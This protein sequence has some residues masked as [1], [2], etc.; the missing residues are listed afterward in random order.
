MVSASTSASVLLDRESFKITRH[1]LCWLLIAVVA[2]IVPHV[3]RMPLWLIAI[4]TLCLAG[5]YLIFQG[6]MSYPG[7]KLKML[8]VCSM[9]LLVAM[10]YGRNVFSTDATVALLLVGIALKLLEMHQKR[11]VLVVLYLAY[12]TVVAEFIYSQTMP[13]A[14]YMGLVV[15]L[16]TSALMA[17]NQTADN[18]A[19]L[20]TAR[21]S[22]LI[23]VQ[24][25][26]LMLVFFL[27][28]PRISPLWAVPA[29]TNRG[30]TGLSDTMAPGD[31]GNLT[32]SAEIAFRVQFAGTPPPY[33]ELYWRALTLNDFDGREWRRSLSD[34]QFF[35][36]GVR[37]VK[38]WFSNIDYEGEA[39][40]YNVIMEPT[41]QNWIFTLMVPQISDERM[42][43]TRDYQLASKRRITQR[44]SY[45]VRS[46]L[47]YQADT[48]TEGG[49][50]RRARMLPATGNP[51]ARQFAQELYARVGSDKEYIDAVLKHFRQEN[52]FY[53]LSPATLG[54]NP[55]D[56]FLF[57]TRE[58]FCEHYASSFTFLMRAAGI[59]ARVVTGY[60]GGAFNPYDGTLTV[61]QYDAHAWSEVWL[62][63]EGWIRVD[64]TAAVAPERIN[65]GSEITLQEEPAFMGDATFSLMRFRNSRLINDLR[66]RLEM[67]DYAWN[68]FVLNYNQDMQSNLLN[69]LFGTLTQPKLLL[70]AAG[71]MMALGAFIALTVFHK[72]SKAS[73]PAAT[74]QYLRF[75]NHMAARGH[76]RQPGETPLHYLER[77]IRLRP[78]WAHEMQT[79]TQLFTE[80]AFAPDHNSLEKPRLEQLRQLRKSVRRLRMLG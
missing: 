1:A 46:F 10:Q 37:E 30:T 45:D 54:D 36:P 50:Q 35:G 76:P 68:R 11:D 29:Q 52:F 13:V 23:L 66:L 67:V 74:V 21:M 49:Q 62:P 42:M 47:Q 40:A 2:V 33:S 26:P 15:V 61:R 44:F 31:I 34:I 59:P 79:I 43:M 51:Q 75:C 63:G 19:P 27:F 12:F 39:V 9:M 17:L 18:H 4:C 22:A 65:Q 57:N 5:R 41:F 80:L 64:P 32:R 38:Q 7:K 56:E 48:G 8:V 24:S 77:L 20:R 69:R 73:K 3:G 14:L 16:I 78:H 55:I 70:A 53:T 71:F 6:R 60:Q 72:S 25:A 28:V 58:G